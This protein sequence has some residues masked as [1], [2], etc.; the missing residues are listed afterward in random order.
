MGLPVTCRSYL[1]NG[2]AG[3][4]GEASEMP[5]LPTLPATLESLVVY[6][7]ATDLDGEPVSIPCLLA[8]NGFSVPTLKI[9]Y[10]TCR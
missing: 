1:G 5:S 9:L 8:R 3:F 2:D 6:A 10:N 4:T 7:S